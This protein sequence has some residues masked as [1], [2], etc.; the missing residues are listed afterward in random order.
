MQRENEQLLLLQARVDTSVNMQT[1]AQ[2]H[3]DD[4]PPPTRHLRDRS[5]PEDA[6]KEPKIP[7]PRKKRPRERKTVDE[8]M[9]ELPNGIVSPNNES[10]ASPPPL[11]LVPL[12]PL[13]PGDVVIP[14]QPIDKQCLE[15]PEPEKVVKK[16]G[17]GRKS[18]NHYQIEE[19]PPPPAAP[20]ISLIQVSTEGVGKAFLAVVSKHGGMDALREKMRARGYAGGYH[21]AVRSHYAARGT[22]ALPGITGV[23]RQPPVAKLGGIDMTDIEAVVIHSI[24]STGGSRP[25]E[26]VIEEVRLYWPLLECFS[27]VTKKDKFADNTMTDSDLAA[28]S[29]NIL[30]ENS[31]GYCRCSEVFLS[32]VVTETLYCVRNPLQPLFKHDTRVG[33]SWMLSRKITDTLEYEQVAVHVQIR[34]D[35]LKEE[36]LT[37]LTSNDPV[38]DGDGDG[39]DRF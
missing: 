32:N 9:P 28:M 14:D 34:M 19:A 15:Q 21:R 26:G 8:S 20:E 36:L 1:I 16:R 39:S 24:L 13:V 3:V 11:P 10:L 22:M 18:V 33:G 35:R 4:E 2:V 5:M 27:E 29:E 7:R 23:A 25:I 12:V 38:C 30:E 31:P 37:I 6:M 17:N